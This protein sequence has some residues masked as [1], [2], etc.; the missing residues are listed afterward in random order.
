MQRGKNVRGKIKI[1]FYTKNILMGG[2]FEKKPIKVNKTNI[3]LLKKKPVGYYS[4]DEVWGF[5]SKG[6]FAIFNP[7]SLATFSTNSSLF[8]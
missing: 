5:P 6:D 7:R 1:G 2:F 8:S 3:Q 4:E